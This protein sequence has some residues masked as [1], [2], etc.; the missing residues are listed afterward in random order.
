MAQQPASVHLGPTQHPAGEFAWPCLE[1]GG[2][3][4][5]PQG[6]CLHHIEVLGASQAA[7]LAL[8]SRRCLSQFGQPGSLR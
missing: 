1:G 5:W 7:S 4:S 2:P 8:G 6:S 3:L